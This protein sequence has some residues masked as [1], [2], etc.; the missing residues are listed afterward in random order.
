M[1]DH[2]ANTSAEKKLAGASCDAH[3]C[4][5]T[6]V[7]ANNHLRCVVATAFAYFAFASFL[8]VYAQTPSA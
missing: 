6:A 1:L 3:E 2:E 8:L 5:V 4:R 7:S